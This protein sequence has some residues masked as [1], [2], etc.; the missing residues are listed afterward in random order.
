MKKLATL[1]LCLAVV[2]AVLPSGA[3][4]AQVFASPFESPPGTPQDPPATIES[5]GDP[6]GSGGGEEEHPAGEIIQALESEAHTPKMSRGA[7]SQVQLI[8]P[9]PTIVPTLRP[10]RRAKPAPRPLW[11][12]AWKLKLLE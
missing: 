3:A 7:H 10:A 5:S 1:L 11:L 9:T 8:V 2:M 12:S 4:P 6:K